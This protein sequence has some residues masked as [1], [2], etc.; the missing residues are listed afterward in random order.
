M[1]PVLFATDHFS[2]LFSAPVL[3]HD[4]SAQLV[5]TQSAR[6]LSS[7][8]PAARLSA[9]ATGTSP[10][11]DAPYVLVAQGQDA[12]ITTQTSKLDPVPV[13]VGPAET[14]TGG[15]GQSVSLRFG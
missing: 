9:L 5:P 2:L 7:L 1:L 11:P 10:L 4:R 13:V 8:G 14:D 3:R 12:L 15:P 6:R